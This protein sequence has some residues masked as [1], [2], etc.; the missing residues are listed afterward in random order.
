MSQ[1][2]Y[3][4]RYEARQRAKGYVRGPRITGEAA[5]R[6]RDLAYVHNL[7]PCE[8]VSRL[9]LGEPL[10]I[11]GNPFGLSPDELLHARLQG[12]AS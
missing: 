7:T 12:Y 5:A 10:P 9:L 6:L 2:P 1:S 8:V 11:P 4:A 3:N